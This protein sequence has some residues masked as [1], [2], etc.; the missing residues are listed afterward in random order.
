MLWLAVA[1]LQYVD[2]ARDRRTNP[3]GED[4][5]SCM[6]GVETQCLAD[7][8]KAG[9]QVPAR[10]VSLSRAK[11]IAGFLLAPFLLATVVI[12]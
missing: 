7:E 8:T 5:G 2:E 1:S 10:V 12:F 9:S 3:L 4:D 6:I 11:L